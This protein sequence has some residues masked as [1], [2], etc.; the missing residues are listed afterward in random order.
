MVAPSLN[1]YQYYRTYTFLP[2]DDYFQWPAED[3]E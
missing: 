2:I 3:L 1:L